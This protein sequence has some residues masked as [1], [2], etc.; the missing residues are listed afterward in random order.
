[1]KHLRILAVMIVICIISAFAFQKEVKETL[2][3]ENV[4]AL[5][6]LD[7]FKTCKMKCID[8]PNHVCSFFSSSGYIV[9]CYEMQ[10]K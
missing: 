6:D 8:A 7:P 9:N 3:N 5:R 2:F 1:M 4:E 10:L